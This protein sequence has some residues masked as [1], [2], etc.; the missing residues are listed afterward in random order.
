MGTKEKREFIIEY[1]LPLQER[2]YWLKVH[3]PIMIGVDHKVKKRGYVS[4]VFMGREVRKHFAVLEWRQLIFCD[5]IS[6]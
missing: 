4:F 1:Q 3:S 2:H 6:I 5:M